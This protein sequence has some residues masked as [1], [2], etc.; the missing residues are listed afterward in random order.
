MRNALLVVATTAL[1]GSCGDVPPT[2]AP[3]ASA[4]AP[5]VLTAP[6][7]SAET[8]TAGA[9][10]AGGTVPATSGDAVPTTERAVPS[11][12]PAAPGST[13][14]PPSTTPYVIPVADA[15][16]AAWGDTHSAYPATDI[17][18]NGCGG[19]IVSPVNGVLLEVRRVNG[20]D[21]VVDDPAARGGRSVSILGD[22]GVRY[23]LAHFE[24][25]EDA[26]DPGERVD[27]GD[28][29]GTIGTTGRSSACHVHF[30]ISPPCPDREYAVRRGVIWPDRYLDDWR[31]GGQASPVDEV[32]AFSRA[33]PDACAE[34]AADPNAANA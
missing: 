20:Y 22:D 24:L 28:L 25:I 33:Q 16:G 8:P 19:A 30:G 3:G 14:T 13:T 15:A 4:T 26:L 2:S 10:S 21:P 18:D 5:S 31:K 32:A 12:S 29:L 1:V 9:G 23:Y 34:A 6:S 7:A 17:F 11:T 27:A